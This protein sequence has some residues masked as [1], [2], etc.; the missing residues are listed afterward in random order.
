MPRFTMR[1]VITL[2]A[3]FTVAGVSSCARGAHTIT[4][5][6]SPITVGASASST[7]H[8]SQM[9]AWA[10]GDGGTVLATKDGGA[11]WAAQSSGTTRLLNSVAFCG[12]ST[13]WAVGEGGIIL[14]TADGGATWKRQDS[15][16]DGTLFAVACVDAKHAWALGQTGSDF[17]TIVVSTA[18]GG[19][20]WTVMPAGTTRSLR[21]I[22]FV[23]ASHGWAVGEFG[24]I[25]ATVDGGRHWTSEN[26]GLSE[27][28]E[29]YGV[30]FSDPVH[31]WAVGDHAPA[32]SNR[33]I[34]LVTDDGG[35]TWTKLRLAAPAVGFLGVS[36]LDSELAWA[37]AGNSVL[38]TANR[39]GTW[40]TQSTSGWNDLSSVAFCTSNV[41]WAVGDQQSASTMSG[42]VFGTSDGGVTWVKQ[43]LVDSC[44][45][46][47]SVVAIAD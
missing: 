39:G 33:G 32:G 44:P 45:Y 6:V 9:L 34:V 19:A 42:V 38:Q 43:K 10:V 17:T 41:G 24:T 16:V 18:D 8:H 28:D 29:L 46:L 26:S 31:G 11:T 4:A 1:L 35:R 7:A 2:V 25:M 13:G 3:L 27:D 30:A 40:R 47:T 22:S 15:H 36:V 37:V 12:A 21:A 23:D 5:S 20:T 14:G